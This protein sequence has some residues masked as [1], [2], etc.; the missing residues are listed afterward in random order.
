MHLLPTMAGASGGRFATK[1]SK[2][3]DYLSNMVDK[4]CWLASR[5]S[6]V[7]ICS[8][9]SH[10]KHCSICLQQRQMCISN[11]LMCTPLLLM[12]R[13]SRTCPD[14][15]HCRLSTTSMVALL[16]GIRD[17]GGTKSNIDD[18]PLP[19]YQKPLSLP[20]SANTYKPSMRVLHHVTGTLSTMVLRFGAYSH[21]CEPTHAEMGQEPWPISRPEPQVY[22]GFR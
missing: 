1:S 21:R 7:E 10:S 17:L 3:I 11:M 19:M 4:H 20:I 6:V 16:R 2:R 13:P 8:P 9:G 12:W 15:M 5:F 22:V 18:L 14:A